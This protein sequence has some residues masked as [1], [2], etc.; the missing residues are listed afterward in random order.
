MVEWE[1][2]FPEGDQRYVRR[3]QSGSGNRADHAAR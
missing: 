2:V 1:L 3:N